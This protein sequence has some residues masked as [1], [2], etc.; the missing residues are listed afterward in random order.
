MARVPCTPH[1]EDSG[2]RVS[3]AAYKCKGKSRQECGSVLRD[4]LQPVFSETPFPPWSPK[5]VFFT[6][7]FSLPSPSPLSSVT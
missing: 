1:P 7:C 6:I 2:T 4:A 3:A 5:P